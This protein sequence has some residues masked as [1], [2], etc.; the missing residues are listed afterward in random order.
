MQHD[1][2]AIDTLRL[3]LAVGIGPV[4]AR[5]LIDHFASPSSVL[6]ASPAQLQHV[7]GIGPSKSRAV[8]D[9]LADAARDLDAELALIE[10]RGVEL[11]PWGSPKYPPILAE[12]ADA[13]PLLYVRGSFDPHGPDRFAVAIVG[14][15][16]CSHYG[17]EQAGRFAG[18]IAG[19]GLTVVSGGAR[20]IDTAAHRGSIIAA[21]RTLAVLGCGLAQVYPPENAELFDRIVNEG[22]GAILSELPM[23]TPPKAENFPARNRIISGLSLGV[24]VVE[25]DER[26]GSLITARLAAEEHGREVFALPGRVDAP[27]SRGT[28]RLI[29]QGG[30]LL[31]TEPAD[32]IHSLESP[33]RRQHAG[34]QVSLWQ[35]VAADTADR[36]EDNPPASLEVS[37]REAR[38]ISRSTDT[39]DRDPESI[40]PSPLTTSFSALT[41][42]QRSLMQTLERE[43]RMTIDQLAAVTG[44]AVHDVRSEVTMLE[45]LRKIRR[46]GSVIEPVA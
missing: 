18:G 15:R 21:G 9:A 14:S 22:R 16:D 38:A 34:N 24:L 23:K 11:I 25:A 2:V 39:P 8:A 35:G 41:P 26:S 17:L 32:I 36:H 10:R 1:P 3:T 31:V 28:N 44:L 7:P 20:G 42:R 45:I 46:S 37:A 5:R 40:M 19:A 13:P 30:A 43:R 33:A 27:A 12:L 29:K 4:L 6:S